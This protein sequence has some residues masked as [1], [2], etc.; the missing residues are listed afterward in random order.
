MTTTGQTVSVT[1]LKRAIEGRDARGLIALYAADAL[2]RI[3]DHDNPPSRPRELKGK[4]A[5][6]AYYER[7]RLNDDAPHRRRHCQRSVAHLHPDLHLVGQSQGV[8]RGDAGDRGQQVVPQLK[9]LLW[10]IK[11]RR[12]TWHRR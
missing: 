7:M 6:A 9:F 3:I 8:L 10:P 5:I 12:I 2:L 1:A 4:P 11:Y